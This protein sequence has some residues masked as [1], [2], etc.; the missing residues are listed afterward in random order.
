MVTSQLSAHNS[1]VAGTPVTWSVKTNGKKPVPVPRSSPQNNHSGSSSLDS[2]S[3]RPIPRSRPKLSPR[4]GPV[5]LLEADASAENKITERP[6]AY[7]RKK[8]D[9]TDRQEEETEQNGRNSLAATYMY[10]LEHAYGRTSEIP[11]APLREKHDSTGELHEKASQNKRNSHLT[12]YMY[13][14]DH[15]HGR[16]RERPKPNLTKKPHSTDRQEEETGQNGRNSLAADYMYDLEHAYGRTSEIPK[17]NLRKKHDSTEEQN[18]GALRNKRNSLET[19]YMYDLEHAHGRTSAGPKANLRKKHD[20]TKEENKEALQNRRN[21][22]S[23]SMTTPFVDQD[24]KFISENEN[25][26]Q[27]HGNSR[28]KS[29][30]K[31]KG[32][33]IAKVSREEF[34]DESGDEIVIDS[35][36]DTR[37][38]GAR[39]EELKWSKPQ[40]GDRSLGRLPKPSPHSHMSTNRAEMTLDQETSEHMYGGT[41]LRSTSLT[42][43]TSMDA[44]PSKQTS[45]DK[46]SSLTE[47][48][49]QRMPLKKSLTPQ[50]LQSAMKSS[51]LNKLKTT[52]IKDTFEEHA[53][54]AENIIDSTGKV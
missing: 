40:T 33:L 42:T 28:P 15:V 51:L 21:Q 4:E 1:G 44:F 35:D 24:G 23:R 9:S 7:L 12:D 25:L 8:H 32:R 49:V 43:K 48:V 31:A 52:D 3:P 22:S 11:K 18:E 14:L 6:R 38:Q 30:G 27:R 50:R 16:T 10:D 13:D 36:Y 39:V 5:N 26:V 19:D 17:A 20:S 45:L 37:R 41:Y 29:L 47:H 34:S 53:P 2:S 46:E 54:Q